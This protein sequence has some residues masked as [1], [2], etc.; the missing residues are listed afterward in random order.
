MFIVNGE[1]LSQK[2][3]PELF[4]W[5]ESQV[6][7]INENIDGEYVIFSAFKKPRFEIDDSGRKRRVQR[8]KSV[9]STSTLN[10]DEF[11]SLTW[12]FVPGANSVKNENGMVI[13]VNPKPFYIGS[14][15]AYHKVKDKDIIFFLLKISEALKNGKI[16]HVDRKRDNIAKA[17]ASALAA[18]A[19]YLLYH[20]SSPI[21]PATTGSENSI[22]QIAISFGVSNVDQLHIAEVRNELWEVILRKEKTRDKALFGYLGFINEAMKIKNASKRA[23]ILTAIEIGLIKY[24]EFKWYLCVKGAFDQPICSVPQNQVRDSKEILIKY[25]LD[26]PE[27]LN[28]LTQSKPPEEFKKFNVGDLNRSELIDECAKKGWERNKLYKMK[29]EKLKYIIENDIQPTEAE[30]ETEEE[31]KNESG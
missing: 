15:Q 2:K 14:D 7:A 6:A 16:H 28:L 27:Y 8:Y 30:F 25:I 9:P 22:R 4:N 11:G 23:V 10:H 18:E 1:I 3:T 13:P 12:T 21:S 17:D 19:Q 31:D 24:D 29:S 26:N 20:K 5:Y